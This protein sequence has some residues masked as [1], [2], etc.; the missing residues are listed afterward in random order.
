MLRIMLQKLWHK[1]WMVMCLLLGSMLLIATVISF[2]LYRN[3]AFDRMLTDEFQNSLGETGLWPCRNEM[4]TIS[5]KE[6]EG[7]SLKR[8]DELMT[9]IYGQLGVTEKESIYYFL[10]G[11]SACESTMKRSD[12]ANL[13]L[14]LGSLSGLPEHAKMLSGEMYSESG[15]SEDGCFEVVVSQNT[16]ISANLLIGEVIQFDALKDMDGNRIKMK[17]VGV[18][19]EENRNDFYWQ[20]KPDEMDNVCLMNEELFRKQFTGDQ[21]ER[22][23]I[24]ANYYSL[25]EYE[26]IKASDVDKLLKETIYLKEESAFKNAFKEPVYREI[27]ESFY[28]KQTRIEATLFILQIPV[29]ILLCAFLFM[30]SGQM[31]DMERN[32][33]SVMK[34]RGGSSGQ[35]LRLYFYQSIFLTALGACV[36]IPLGTVF[37]RILGS[38]QN[39]LEFTATRDLNIAF[40]G[41]VFVYI[42]VVC[43]ASIAIMTIPALKHSRLTIVKLKQSNALRKRSWW[44]KLFLDVV[45]LGIAIYGFYSFSQNK[46]AMVQNVLQGKSLDP[47]LYISSSLFIV[48]CG[49]LFLRLQPLFVRLIYGIGKKK[50][51]PASYASFMENIKNGRKQQFIMLFMILTISLGMYHATVA[52]T[53]LQNAKDNAEYIQPADII[54]KEQWLDNSAS[55]ASASSQGAS[56]EKIYTEPDF[57]KYS[58]I[59]GAASYTK[60]LY[61]T[62]AKYMKSAKDSLDITL[63]GIHTKEFGNITNMN[64]ALL[65]KPY[66]EYLNELA[67]EPKGVL[68]SANFRDVHGMKVGE[69]F[70]IK[71]TD[72]NSI[73]CKIVDFINYF[74]GYEPTSTFL[75]PDQTVERTDNLLVIANIGTLQQKWGVTPYEVWV[76]LADKSDTEGVYT[77]LEENDVHVKKFVDKDFELKKVVEDP[78]LQGTNGVLTMGFIVTIILC[79]VGY[80]IYW[81]MSIRSREMIFG[82]LRACG[83]HKGELFHML[84][85]EQLFSGVLSIFAGIGIGKITSK[86][87]V[88][89][90]QTAYAASNQVLPM[91]LITNSQ[92]M[93]RLYSV[94]AAVMASCL[95]ILIVLVFKLNVTKALK[96]GEE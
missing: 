80:L 89:M 20:V 55:S 14:R 6:K 95:G 9:G 8:M 7:K 17:I 37:C 90:L 87:F 65:E 15:L 39:F 4:V 81:I 85:N 57:A 62:K 66:Y 59:P 10:Q 24:T 79:A 93:V 49:L 61:D 13:S 67:V 53:I 33:I 45:S 88:P 63:M 71:D 11:L 23:T 50:W 44:E 83:M 12:A 46:E 28:K 77:W 36:G 51:K 64:D 56:K 69:N 34:S 82:I 70:D 3:A 1:K 43:G 41:D 92:D 22:Y 27:L 58:R 16:M 47:L 73:T 76:S 75:N 86:M 26:D 25:F 84:F 52:R 29:L 35:M 5:K 96:L 31:Y 32:E 94:V 91:Q 42:L 54:V 40:T 74:P 19:T 68:L 18:F 72:G 30:I 78:L 48:G 2:P 60:V 21:A 38:A